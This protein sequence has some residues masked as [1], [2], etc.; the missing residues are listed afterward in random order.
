MQGVDDLSDMLIYACA[1]MLPAASAAD[2]QVAAA[3]LEP[4]YATATPE[5]IAEPAPLHHHH[6]HHHHKHL[7]QVDPTTLAVAQGEIV[8]GWA[9][10]DLA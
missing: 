5:G 1:G 8:S 2:G 3:A 7:L 6:H 4:T 9:V 10:S